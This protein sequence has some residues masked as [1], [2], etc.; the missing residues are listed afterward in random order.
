[1]AQEKAHTS[2]VWSILPINDHEYITCSNDKFIKVWADNRK[3]AVMAINMG[4]PIN[5]I[6]SSE[7]DNRG[8][9][10]LLCGTFHGSV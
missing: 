9:R 6:A 8:E 4:A 3:A 10:I 1:M 7:E 5:S 2:I